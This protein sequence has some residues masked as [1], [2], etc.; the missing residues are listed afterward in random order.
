MSAT[1][2][3]DEAPSPIQALCFTYLERVGKRE[4][5]SRVLESFVKRTKQ[6][7]PDDIRSSPRLATKWAKAV[8]ILLVAAVRG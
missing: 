4:M 5:G 8:R 6:V 1:Y 3:A 7:L 2:V